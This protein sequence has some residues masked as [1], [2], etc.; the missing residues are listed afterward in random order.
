MLLQD[1]QE[2]EGISFEVLSQ[3]RSGEFFDHPC[4]M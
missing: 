4:E 2:E 1:L 3:D